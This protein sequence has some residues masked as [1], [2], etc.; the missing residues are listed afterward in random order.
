[1]AGEDEPAPPYGRA[2]LDRAL[3]AER[4]AI[5]RAERQLAAA[6]DDPRPDDAL[7]GALADLGVRRR[8]AASLELCAA[9]NRHCPPRLDEPAWSYDP[10]GSAQPELDTELRFSRASW[11]R[12][13]EELDGRACACRTRS[14]VESMFAAIDVLEAQPMQDIRA[15][16]TASEWITRARQCLFRLRGE[17]R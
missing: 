4:D 17:T 1:M 7:A 14:C 11:Q 6:Q 13:A 15:D 12:I 8:F 16:E 2:E 10:M 3:A 5:A 9:E